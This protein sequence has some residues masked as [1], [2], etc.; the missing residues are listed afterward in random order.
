M[1]NYI[2]YRLTDIRR[3]DIRLVEI[4]SRKEV[5][6]KNVASKFGKKRRK[7]KKGKGLGCALKGGFSWNGA[8]FHPGKR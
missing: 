2:G 3:M 4:L 1:N 5:T 7:R 6:Q 8:T